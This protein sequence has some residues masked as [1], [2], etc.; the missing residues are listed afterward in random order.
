MA[1]AADTPDFVRQYIE[2]HIGEFHNRRLASLDK[3]KLDQLLKRKNPYL[4][5]ATFWK[6][7]PL[8]CV[9]MS[10]VGRNLPQKG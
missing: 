10:M 9:G 8:K 6:D 2:Q 7:L 1:M 4:F 5:L 3:L